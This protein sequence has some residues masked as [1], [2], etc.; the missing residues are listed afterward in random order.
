MVVP[1]LT[2]KVLPSQT[3]IKENIRLDH[4]CFCIF[5]SL[6]PIQFLISL[7]VKEDIDALIHALTPILYII[8]TG[9]PK[10]PFL[11]PSVIQHLTDKVCL[12]FSLRYNYDNL[13]II[14]GYVKSI[15]PFWLVSK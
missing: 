11:D 12:F 3:I 9:V 8:K 1:F 5:H 6:E 15:K 2:Y 4:V 13:S 7:Q 10:P 14:A